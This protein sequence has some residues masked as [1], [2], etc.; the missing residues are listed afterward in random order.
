MNKDIWYHVMCYLDIQDILQC[1]IISKLF[2][3]VASIQNLW[4][5]KLNYDFGCNN[6]TISE[7]NHYAAK[8]I[9][10]T[11]YSIHCLYKANSCNMCSTNLCFDT[12]VP[13]L[14]SD[15]KYNTIRYDSMNNLLTT[16]YTYKIDHTKSIG[17]RN[18]RLLLVSKQKIS[19]ELTE[20]IKKVTLVI[21]GNQC[22]I[23][24]KNT[25]TIM[26]NFYG[27]VQKLPYQLA[28]QLI[29]F[30]QFQNQIQQ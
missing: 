11:Y 12:F 16:Q 1:S 13:K 23:F 6:T 27:I 7:Q 18:I 8:E 20:L 10:K 9:Y 30:H 28:Q 14:P 25:I 17:Y 5:N 29:G 15:C 22:S 3:S 24:T 19:C 4:E 26:H 21:S 2:H